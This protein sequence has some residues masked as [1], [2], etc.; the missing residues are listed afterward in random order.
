MVLASGIGVACMALRGPNT[1]AYRIALVGCSGSHT[2]PW[3][4]HCGNECSVEVSGLGLE[5]SVLLELDIADGAEPEEF[6]FTTRGTFPFPRTAKRYR[7]RKISNG[8]ATPTTVKV[9]LH[10]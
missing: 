9:H 8:A 3:T 7:I 1:M 2:T 10:G 6:A 5:E 4:R